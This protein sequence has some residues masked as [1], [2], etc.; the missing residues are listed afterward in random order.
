MVVCQCLTF[1]G[2]EA[3]PGGAGAE[4]SKGS[5]EVKLVRELRTSCELSGLHS[6]GKQEPQ[7]GA[8]EDGWKGEGQETHLES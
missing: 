6:L 4:P 5:L 7:P 3:E 8:L 1:P 2:K